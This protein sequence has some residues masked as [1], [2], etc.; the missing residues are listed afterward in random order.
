MNKLLRNSN[1]E[2]LRIVL[3]IMVIIS[4]FN[5]EMGGASNYVEYGS[6]NYYFLQLL[7]SLSVCA[8]NCFMIISGYF[9]AYNKTVK[10]NKIFDILLTVIVYRLLDYTCMV[11]FTDKQFSLIVFLSKFLPSNYFAVFYVITYIF[12]PFFVII[13]DNISEKN[14]KKL[15]ILII[16]IFCI[17]PSLIDLGLDIAP[18][19]PLN[20]ISPISCIGNL[21]GYSI[22]NFFVMFFIGM[23]LRRLNIKK[24]N[25]LLLTIF[26]IS[27]ITLTLLVQKFHSLYNY[28]SIFTIINAVCLFL[29]FSNFKFQNKIINNISKSVFSIFCIHT[30]SFP[31]IYWR[32]FFVTNEHLSNSFHLFIFWT[33]L[34]ILTMFIFCLIIDI[35]YRNTLK[36][37]FNRI[38]KHFK[39]LY[40]LED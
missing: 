19:L 14:L 22:I 7:Q 24:S 2:S 20:G 13:F 8:V 25:I 1:I 29:L 39:L 32:K 15:L 18:S 28:C 23:Y 38:S 40:S 17:L 11:L 33:I 30:S 5:G 6:L 31:L 37:L 34:S 36:K 35:I 12:S 10:L 26:F 27:S 9:L 21:N 16:C 4:H 3:I